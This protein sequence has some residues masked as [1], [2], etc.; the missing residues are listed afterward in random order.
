MERANADQ[1]A[2]WLARGER[3]GWSPG[4]LARRSGHPVWKL[5]W[6]RKRFAH[7]RTRRRPARAFVAVELSEPAPSPGPAVVTLE[8]TTPSGHRV[9]VP[10][11]FDAAHLRRRLAALADAC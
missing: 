1:M 8:V 3:A 7:M 6:W 5:R 9:A 11:D 4:E 10:A 2:R